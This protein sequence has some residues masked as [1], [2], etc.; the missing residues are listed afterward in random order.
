MGKY[1]NWVRK[2]VNHAQETNLD[3]KLVESKILKALSVRKDEI[4]KI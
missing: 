1:A 2:F 3:Y 4:L